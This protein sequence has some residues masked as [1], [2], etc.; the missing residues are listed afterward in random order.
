M[1]TGI[2]RSGMRQISIV[3]ALTVFLAF[4]AGRLF[5]KGLEAVEDLLVCLS[6]CLPP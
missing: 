2:W 1:L 6:A 4:P 3:V 5:Q